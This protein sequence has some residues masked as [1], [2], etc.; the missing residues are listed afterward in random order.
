MEARKVESSAYVAA[1][2]SRIVVGWPIYQDIQN[3]TQDTVLRDSR[4]SSISVKIPN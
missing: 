3:G 1:V 4:F 2:A